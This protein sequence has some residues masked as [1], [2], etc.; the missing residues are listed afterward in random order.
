MGPSFHPSLTPFSA[1]VEAMAPQW[2]PSCA[3]T[4]AVS[5]SVVDE[6]E[7]QLSEGRKEQLMVMV[8]EVGNSRWCS[9]EEL[10][11][12]LPE[13][14]HISEKPYACSVCEYRSSEQSTLAQ[15]GRLHHSE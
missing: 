11:L 1:A 5:L 3:S 7:S 12:T 10:K 15:H 14:V 2:Q 4:V 9:G 6:A 8:G 13:C